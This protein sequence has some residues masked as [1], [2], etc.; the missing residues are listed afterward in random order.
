MIEGTQQGE[1]ALPPT[2]SEGMQ[3]EALNLA[4]EEKFR[5]KVCGGIFHMDNG[6]LVFALGN[7]A[8]GICLGPNN[9]SSKA[10]IHITPGEQGVNI[11]I[12]R[13]QES[14]LVVPGN[15]A[16]AQGMI[17]NAIASRM[18]REGE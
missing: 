17:K 12:S 6:L 8:L 13:Q 7:V 11:K 4:L 18:Q 10:G 14:S 9:C 1:T 5:C 15:S 3:A 2:T 16:V